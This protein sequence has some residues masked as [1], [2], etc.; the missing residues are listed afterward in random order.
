MK[1]LFNFKII[2]KIIAG[3]FLAY[4]VLFSIAASIALGIVSYAVIAP[5][6]QVKHLRTANPVETIYMKQ[7]KALLASQHKPNGLIQHFVP[8]DSISPYLLKSVLAAE[9]DGFY[10]HPGFDINAIAQAIDYNRASNSVR[11]GASTITQQLA[12]NLFAGGEKSF[13]RKYRE[14]V[15]ALLMEWFLGKDRILE[16]YMN[17]AQWGPNIF[18]CE[19]AAREYYQKS[20]RNLSVSE[21]ARLAAMLAKPS[22]VNPHSAQ[23]IFMQKR[24]S[25][26]ANNLYRRHTIDSTMWLELGG[27]DSS[28]LCGDADSDISD[29]AA[30]PRHG[31]SSSGKTA[32]VSNTRRSRF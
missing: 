24:L 6:M 18:G 26:I 12:K 32:S 10:Y 5:V 30:G 15:Y 22:K 16:L 1:S 14:L 2:L 23:S 20:S 8:L 29:A 17:Y 21:A 31:E 25:V 7:Q 9:D 4:A 27:N 28:L 19:A 11:H 3:I 13:D